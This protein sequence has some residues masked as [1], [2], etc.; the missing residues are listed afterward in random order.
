MRSLAPRND[1]TRGRLPEFLTRPFLRTIGFLALVALVC[2]VLLLPRLVGLDGALWRAILYWRSCRTDRLVDDVVHVTT[3]GA[4]A[5]LAAAVLLRL[6]HD[7]VRVVWPPLVLCLVGV[8]VGKLLKNVFQ[9]ERPSMLPGAIPGH[10]FP[11]GH[12]M[13]TTLAAI[14]VVMLAAT[15]RHPRRWGGLALLTMATIF[16]GRLVLAHHWFLDAVGA[17]LAALALTGLALPALRRR[18]L[19]VPAALALAI[20]L[21]L[22]F[23]THARGRRITLPSPLSA[24]ADGT[25]AHPAGLLGSDALQG[26]WE[27]T[28]GQF[29]RGGYLWLHGSG[30]VALDLDTPPT[31]GDGVHPVP[32]GSEAT[33]AIGGRP[34]L[35][36]RRCLTFRVH[37]NEQELRPFVP[38][39][40]WRE[41]R[42]L[43]P[44]GTLRPGRNDVRLELTDVHGEPWRFAVAYVRLDRD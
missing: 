33:L 25:E 21:V 19:V 44:P 30:T 18:P 8:Y 42:L 3:L 11:S 39:V 13:N 10:S 5:L 40:G 4:A 23:V 2:E 12:V 15:F 20:T 28:V 7:G 6:R 38:F 17:V 27:P 43:L 31:G 22:A 29:R 26:A 35:V 14:A 16:L 32:T 37:V 1:S 34:D 24:S 41:Y 36:E 9:R